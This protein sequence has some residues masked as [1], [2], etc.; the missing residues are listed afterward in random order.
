MA[1]QI[2]IC[3]SL[4]PNISKATSRTQRIYNRQK[5]H[6]GRPSGELY[7]SVKPPLVQIIILVKCNLT[8]SAKI[9]IVWWTTRLVLV[10]EFALTRRE[11][12]WECL[13]CK[14]KLIEKMIFLRPFRFLKPVSKKIGDPNWAL[15]SWL[16]EQLKM[17]MKSKFYTIYNLNIRSC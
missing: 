7:K 4:G 6:V 14:V 15:I 5:R 10:I 17:V 2:N 13:D 8:T 12:K 1:S 9:L 3:I 11:D 16:Y